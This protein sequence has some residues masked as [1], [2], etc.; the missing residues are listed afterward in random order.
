MLGSNVLDG[1]FFLFIFMRRDRINAIWWDSDGMVITY[2]RMKQDTFEIPR[3]CGSSSGSN[4]RLKGDSQTGAPAAISRKYLTSQLTQSNSRCCLGWHACR[5]EAATQASDQRTL[6]IH[7]STAS[8]F[9]SVGGGVFRRRMF[10]RNDSN[11]FLYAT[12]FM[13]VR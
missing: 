9:F 1:H 13:H 6:E 7:R 11:L 2:K 8:T 12:W 10:W 4:K 5:C 3:M